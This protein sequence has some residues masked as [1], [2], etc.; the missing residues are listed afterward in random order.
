MNPSGDAYRD[1]TDALKASWDAVRRGWRIVAA[2]SAG[3]LTVGILWV[4]ATP[5]AY[6][7]TLRLLI[8]ANAASPLGL[9]G[10]EAARAPDPLDDPI[11]TQ[12]MI[13]RSTSVVGRAVEELG[14]RGLPS[15]FGVADPV[16]EAI[17]R[18]SVTR[19]DRTAKVLQLDVS[20]GSREEAVRLAEAIADSHRRF[21]D[22][23]GRRA[24]SGVVA[25]LGRARDELRAEIEA[26]EQRLRDHRARHPEA[27]TGDSARALALRAVEP[28]ERAS[29]E[30]TV[31]AV[32]L[33]AQLDLGRSLS[34]EGK[35]ARSIALALGLIDEPGGGAI[36]RLGDESSGEASDYLR[37]IKDELR[38]QTEALGPGS[39]KARELQEQLQRLSARPADLLD[40][41]AGA[42][43]AAETLR[44]EYSRRRDRALAGAG[45]AEGAASDADLLRADLDRSRA[46]FSAV[47]EQIK[48]A[49]IA[50][51]RPPISARVIE[52]AT[53]PR[54]PIRP[55][56]PMTL[57][58]SLV[59][60]LVL[61]SLA[62]VVAD[63]LDPGLRSPDLMQ[64]ALGLSVLGLIP[65]ETALPMGR[66][67]LAM[68]R[69]VPSEAFKA[70]RTHVEACRIAKNAR[71]ILVTSPRP[72]EGKSTLASN[73]AIATAQAGRRV[74]LIDADL[75]RPTQG[76]LHGAG[77]APGSPISSRPTTR[78]ASA[79]A[80]GPPS[81]PGSTS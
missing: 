54:S 64:E 11:P 12:A 80:S 4:A 24:G 67:T 3:C 75:R 63:R 29:A 41:V 6:Q 58:L 10:F 81:L 45:A 8:S 78:R 33:R 70:A 34:V 17:S 51:D 42:L 38:K 62:S 49:E 59:A 25:L 32:R 9:G 66:V 23:N 15:L 37:R 20:A 50:G 56:V 5:R 52:P 19:P 26:Q 72:E 69:S 18:T 40:A 77:A 39:T 79:S 65:D 31:R 73:L 22:E 2:V 57:G 16:R 14:P 1:P 61:G 68:P 43:R 27:P 55:K 71:I 36:G 7:A 21:L 46:L 48:A 76:R 53:S 47:V 30:A 13:L 60:G 35:D 44:D 28:W 74:L